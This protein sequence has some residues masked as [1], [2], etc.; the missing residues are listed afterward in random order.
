MAIATVAMAKGRVKK[1]G[2][3]IPEEAFCPEYI[4]AELEK[5]EIYIHEEIE[6]LPEANGSPKE[7]WMSV[8]SAPIS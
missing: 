6:E 5:H 7:H 8:R 3:L 2:V 4:P 1:T